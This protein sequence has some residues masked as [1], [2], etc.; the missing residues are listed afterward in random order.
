MESKRGQTFETWARCLVL[1]LLAAPTFQV[2]LVALQLGG[3]QTP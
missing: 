1:S 2:L 3:Q